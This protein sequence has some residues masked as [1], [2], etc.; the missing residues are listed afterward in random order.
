M[1][2]T[3]FKGDVLIHS[4]NDG[5]EIDVEDGL[6]LDCNTFSTAVY[7]SLFGGNKDDDAGRSKE[8]WW[9]NLIPGTVENERVVSHFQAVICGLPLTSG[10]LKKAQTAAEL[11][12]KWLKD[13]GIAD[14]VTVTLKAE[15]V[16]RVCASVEITK[17]GTSLFESSYYFE[18]EGARNGLR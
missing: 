1:S 3:D 2:K 11:D 12:L 15:D 4:T 5:G 13:E 18:W 8:T 6:I 7:I 16:K 17:D 9:G 14:S 10:N